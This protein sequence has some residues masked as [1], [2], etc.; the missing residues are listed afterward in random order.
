MFGTLCTQLCTKHMSK[1]TYCT[2]TKG[3]VE[4]A[5]ATIVN[6]PR[7]YVAA[8]HRNLNPFWQPSTYLFNTQVHWLTRNVPFR[9]VLIGYPHGRNTFYSSSVFVPNSYYESK[10]PALGMK[11]FA[12]IIALQTRLTNHSNSA[13]KKY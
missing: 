2:K 9:I 1:I 10:T 3:K 11:L 8:N 4:R 12:C 6:C 7:K 5:S 13:Q